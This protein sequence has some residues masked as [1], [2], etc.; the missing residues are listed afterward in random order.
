MVARYRA[1]WR[2]HPAS[3]FKG[4]LPNGWVY[5]CADIEAPSEAEAEAKARRLVPAA[6]EYLGLIALDAEP[7]REATTASIVRHPRSAVL[8]KSA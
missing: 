8:T 6:G 5:R 3:S 1:N 7:A 2:E 4:T